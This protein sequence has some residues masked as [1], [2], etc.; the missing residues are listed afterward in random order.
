M[1]KYR[2]VKDKDKEALKKDWHEEVKLHASFEPDRSILYNDPHNA[3]A[4]RIALSEV[5]K[6]LSTASTL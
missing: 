2:A 1:D 5:K 6:L 3:R 4:C